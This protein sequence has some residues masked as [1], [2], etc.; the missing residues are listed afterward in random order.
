MKIQSRWYRLIGLVALLLPLT[1]TAGE[2]VILTHD[3]PPYNFRKN[4]QYVGINTDIVTSALK[5]EKVK[6]RIQTLNWARAQ[7]MVQ[8]TPDTA[9]LSAGRSEA[10]ERL[11]D[12]VGPLISSRSFLYGLSRRDDYKI[13]SVEDILNYRISVTRKGVMVDQFI[14][15]GL[16]ESKNLMLV[17]NA[18]DTY[19]AIFKGRADLIVGSELTV[20]YQLRSLGYRVRALKPIFEIDSYSVD[21]YLAVNKGMS[22]ELI[23]RLNRRIKTMHDSGQMEKIIAK[24][25]L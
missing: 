21:N 13:S 12:W 3:F 9:L 2:L 24:Y 23:E 20:P 16:Y 7:K 10:R 6:F 14:R 19:R 18:S 25:R 17:A 1:A 15:L 8:S 22:K 5:A 4:N 11:Y